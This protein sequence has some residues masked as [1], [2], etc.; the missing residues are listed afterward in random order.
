VHREFGGV[1]DPDKIDV[2]DAQVRFH[3][4]LIRVLSWSVL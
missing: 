3:R 1:K 2:D 4:F